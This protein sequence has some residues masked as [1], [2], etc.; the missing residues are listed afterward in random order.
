MNQQS[1]LRY[2]RHF[3]LKHLFAIS[4]FCILFF[5]LSSQ[6]YGGLRR[7]SYDEA[8]R[9]VKAVSSTAVYT[10]EFDAGDNLLSESRV[11]ILHGDADVSMTIDLIDAILCLQAASGEIP[12]Q[13]VHSGADYDGDGKLGIQEVIFILRYVAGL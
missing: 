2:A 11:P 4:V 8:G 13:T 12:S 6:V 10:Y 1:L 7:Y 5:S 9:L 3:T